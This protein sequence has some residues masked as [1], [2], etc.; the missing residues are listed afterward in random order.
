MVRERWNLLQ[1]KY[2]RKRREEEGA[3]GIQ[4]TQKDILIEELCEL[5]DVVT[6]CYTK[7]A[8]QDGSG[9]YH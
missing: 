4:P 5:G 3:S 1:G 6:Q 9:R 2:K 7:E 8:R